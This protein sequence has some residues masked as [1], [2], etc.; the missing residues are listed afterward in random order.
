MRALCWLLLVLAIAR[1]SLAGTAYIPF[2]A[3]NRPGADASRSTTVQLEI[4]NQGTVPRRY[5]VSLVRAGED[6]SRGGTLVSG[7]TLRPGERSTLACCDGASGLLI[8][9]GAPQIVVTAHLGEAFNQP[10]PNTIF[11]RLPLLTAPDALPAGA[12]T[13][14][15]KLVWEYGDST[16]SSLGILNLGHQPAHCS[17]ARLDFPEQFPELQSIGV[18]AVSLAAFPSVLHAPVFPAAGIITH[19]EQRP[20]VT[21]DQPFYPFALVYWGLLGSSLPVGL[22]WVEFVPPAVPLGSVP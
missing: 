7:K 8:V 19:F 9:S 14:L 17:V 18:P 3:Q 13:S 10:Q 21:C 6:G 11:T 15:Q 4:Y 2:V 16:T 22:P 5:T 12:P 1:P 20:T